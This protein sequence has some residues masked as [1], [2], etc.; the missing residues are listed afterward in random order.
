[1]RGEI[2]EGKLLGRGVDMEEFGGEKVEWGFWGE[3]K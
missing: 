3:K 1:V 2:D